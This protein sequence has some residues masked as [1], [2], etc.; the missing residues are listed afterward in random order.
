MNGYKTPLIT[1]LF[2]LSISG[3][4]GLSGT[5]NDEQKVKATVIFNSLSGGGLGHSEGAS[6]IS[7]EKDLE[8]ALDKLGRQRLGAGMTVFPEIDF[9]HEGVLLI[10][11]GLKYTGG[12]GIELANDKV[13][14]RNGLA[15]VKVNWIEPD[16]DAVLA[17]M[18]NNPFI[19]IKLT[20][21]GFKRI[22]VTDQ[23][24]IIRA[25]TTVKEGAE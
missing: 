21:K 25:E 3:C 6:W 7:D 19:M 5:V 14:L 11:M 23:N 4:A 8:S 9:N 22:Q 24:N 2:I 12:Y 20:G 18:I 10:R 16:K 17:Q 1:I 15:V 13:S